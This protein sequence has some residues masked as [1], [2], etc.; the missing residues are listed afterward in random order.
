MEFTALGTLADVA[1]LKPEAP[2]AFMQVASNLGWGA[3][4]LGVV[5]LLGAGLRA[6]IAK[7]S[8]EVTDTVAPL[9]IGG[10]ILSSVGLVLTLVGP[11]SDQD[12]QPTSPDASPVPTPPAPAEPTPSAPEAPTDYT[13]LWI[14]CGA[15]AASLIVI[16]VAVLAYHKVSQARSH[17]AV[18][19]KS[20]RAQWV[21]AADVL[22]TIDADYAAYHADLADRLFTRPLLD[23][24]N[25]PH[26]AAF[27]D[28][29]TA[30]RA[31][32]Y[33]SR[34][35]DRDLAERA[36]T[37]ALAARDAWNTASR[38]ARDT[39]LNIQPAKRGKLTR[40][41]KMLDQALDPT[42]TD[43]YR[44]NLLDRITT[45]IAEAGARRIP[46]VRALVAESVQRQLDTQAKRP[47]LQ[48]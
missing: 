25:D 46:P 36:V 2:E 5:I 4:I 19:V 11:D 32:A 22:G 7:N 9:A 26:T 12:R 37:N 1:P 45:L 14:I 13:T 44:D 31:A 34:P 15:V 8:G 41:R 42:I 16:A 48:R 28:A 23:D 39:G 18:L 29:Y 3:S 43:A 20:T 30:A 10:V 21:K 35:L 27:L 47:Q 17:R 33:D 40:A 38:H 24:T 6:A